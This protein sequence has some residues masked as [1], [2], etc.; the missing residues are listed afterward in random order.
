MAELRKLKPEGEVGTLMRSKQMAAV[1]PRKGP[2]GRSTGAYRGLRVL[3]MRSAGELT[4]RLWEGES[5]DSGFTPAAQQLPLSYP[6]RGQIDSW[7]SLNQRDSRFEEGR[8]DGTG[9]GSA[10]R[11]IDSVKAYRL[12]GENPK[13]PPDSCSVAYT[14]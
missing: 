5:L 11:C 6:S 3:W 9:H 8:M 7:W 4:Q 10:G 1:G 13:H 12:K 2:G 14:L